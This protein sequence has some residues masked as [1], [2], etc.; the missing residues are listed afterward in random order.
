M[1]HEWHGHK[2]YQIIIYYRDVNN[3]HNHGCPFLLDSSQIKEFDQTINENWSTTVDEL[4]SFSYFNTIERM[5]EY[6][7]TKTIWLSCSASS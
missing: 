6:E 5:L 4:V 1:F 2:I 7:S 3:G